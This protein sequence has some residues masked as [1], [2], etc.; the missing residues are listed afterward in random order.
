M[1]LKLAA[2]LANERPI[3]ARV[4]SREDCIQYITLNT[5]LLG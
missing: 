4:Q 1:V 2:N 5:V 3:D